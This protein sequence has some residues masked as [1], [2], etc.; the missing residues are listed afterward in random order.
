MNNINLN[1][2]IPCNILEDCSDLRA[3]T[4]KIGQIARASSIFRVKKIIIYS[5]NK[6]FYKKYLDDIELIKRILEYL[7]CPQYLRRIIFPKI[8]ILKYVGI[9][10]PLRTPHHPLEDKISKL[11]PSSIREG[12]VLYSNA[13]YSELEIGLE[14]PLKLDVPNLPEKKRIILKL[15]KQGN[16]IS[17]VPIEKESIEEY[18]GYEIQVFKGSLQNF[19]SSFSDYTAIATSK[20]GN[21]IKMN[22]IEFIQQ[23]QKKDGILLLFG[24]PNYGLFEIFENQG[25]N[26]ENSV[27]FIINIASNQ[28]TQTVRVEEAIYFALSIINCILFL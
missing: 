13:F 1:I 5:I 3:K 28:G 17:G 8:P 2:A 25:L 26:L 7:D 19:I 23:L 6:G 22:D 4:L 27:D 15:E 9:L 10:P 16:S 20:R 14:R 21:S 12:T 18:W 24:S 11:Q